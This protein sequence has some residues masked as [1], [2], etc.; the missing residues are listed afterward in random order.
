MAQMEHAQGGGR[1]SAFEI[2]LHF[3][4][5]WWWLALAPLPLALW[6][7]ARNGSGRAALA[8]LADAALLPH[9]LADGGARRRFALGLVAT[10][11]LL[12]VAALSG[13]AWQ[14]L[15]APLYVNGAAR[16]VVL[17]LSDD[18]LAQDA[19]PD[20]MTRARFAVRD[21]LN[22]AGDARMALVAYAGAAFTVAPLTDDKN[23]ILNL[24]QALKPDVMPVP[25][26][27]AAA[28]IR[29]GI[30]L[31]QQAH[32]KGGE[33]VLV[34]DTADDAAVAQAKAARAKNIRVD[35]LGVGTREGAPV[36]QRGGG[37]ASG[38]GGTLMARRDDVALRAVADAGGGRYVVLQADGTGAA[39]FGA[40]VAE[41]GHAS[42]GERA[43]LWRDGGIWLLPV[44][45]VLAALAFRRGWLLVFALLVL[46]VGMPKAHAGTWDS[47]WANRDQ[48]ALQ[49]LQHGDAAQA[50]KL[51]STPG[52][53]GAADYRAGNYADAA[54]AFAQG[55]DARAR[56]NLGN[57][58]AKQ[59]EYEKAIAAYKQALQRDPKMAD[60]RANLDAVE[61]WL[62]KHQQ[63]SPQ[64][65]RQN[66]NGQPSS[67]SGGG[68]SSRNTGKD[69]G[70]SGARQGAASSAPQASSATG[71]NNAA[72]KQGAQQQGN[73]GTAQ[74]DHDTS[75]AEAAKQQKQTQQ[76]RQALAREMQ[77]ARKTARSEKQGNTN[78][79]A[80]GE[81][82]PKQ[83]G[84]FDAQQRAILQA[85]PDDPGALLRRK[86][87]LEWEQRNGRQPE[88]PQQ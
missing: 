21:L 36:P 85:V 54:K 79:F 35:V 47:L 44:L 23:T 6:M 34:A 68:S 45:L 60:A 40:P 32:A 86:F 38:S 48:R 8:K 64:S 61:D 41:A 28:G 52:V 46:P 88:E 62:K 37:F 22:D 33:I 83:D 69:S 26:N 3:L 72:G 30:E 73:A 65:G 9:L 39:A 12:A 16:V 77:Q 63:H 82:A 51:A 18:M 66:S 84:Q 4:R 29:Q 11:W 81:D 75:A 56:Y 76:A 24:L 7:L 13:P 87:R 57:A 78:A 14:K 67:S 50:R 58:L 42:R 19:Q 20:R 80:L 10:A 17:S 43:Q 5:P 15:P 31:L 25:G 1:M 27:D 2:P 55:D 71:A 49:A 74:Q 70:K 59:G 53:R